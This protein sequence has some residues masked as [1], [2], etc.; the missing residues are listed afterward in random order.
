MSF[1]ESSMSELAQRT[2]RRRVLE[3][4]R[5]VRTRARVC[6]ADRQLAWTLGVSDTSPPLA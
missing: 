5:V 2:L 3:I 1:K 4:D 6:Y